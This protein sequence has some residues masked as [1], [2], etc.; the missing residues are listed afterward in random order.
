[1]VWV[2]MVFYFGEKGYTLLK[3]IG[4]FSGLKMGVIIQTSTYCSHFTA[5]STILG[6]S[7]TG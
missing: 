2:P 5:Q 4:I 3:V 7:M 1:M 6:W